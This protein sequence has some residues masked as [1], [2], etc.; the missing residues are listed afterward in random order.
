VTRVTF[1][2]ATLADVIKRAAVV[3]PSKAGASF[4]KAAGVM[5]DITPNDPVQVAVRATNLDMWFLEVVDVLSASGDDRRWRLPSGPFSAILANQAS[6]TNKQVTLHDEDP[7]FPGRLMIQC[8]HLRGG[9]NLINPEHYP[10]FEQTSEIDF[11][12]ISSLGSTID[13]V[14]WAAAKTSSDVLA[15]VHFDGTYV[16]A[17]DRSRMAR[18][19]LPVDLGVPVTVAAGTLPQLLRH[20]GEVQIGVD[21]KQLVI[22]PDGVT[23]IVVNTFGADYPDIRKLMRLDYPQAVEI[24]KDQLVAAINSVLAVAGADRMPNVTLFFGRE[25]FAINL[26]NEDV[27]NIGDIIP[28]PG[29]ITH[30]RIEKGMNPTNLL[31][32][33]NHAPGDRVTLRYDDADPIRGLLLVEGGSGYY[34]WLVPRKKMG[35]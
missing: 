24:R 19:P 18:M 30:D 35:S 31:E 21:G 8:G 9:L 10:D 22:E 34:V 23:R 33:I 15:G 14:S 7:K 20:Q 3:A 11:A 27:G 1:E 17:T 26:S 16:V 4:D 28:C 2:A 5:L 25:Q 32:A 29:Q 13:R 6:G 12:T